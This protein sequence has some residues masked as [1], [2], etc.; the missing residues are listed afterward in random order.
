M[1]WRKLICFSWSFALLSIG[2][3]YVPYRRHARPSLPLHRCRT[4]IRSQLH[5]SESIDSR[6]ITS[7]NQARSILVPFDSQAVAEALTPWSA[8]SNSNT[9]AIIPTS[10]DAFNQAENKPTGMDKFIKSS[11]R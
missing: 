3:A 5:S 9:K 7:A 11:H 2:C 4:S 1:D 6:N 8:E 10:P